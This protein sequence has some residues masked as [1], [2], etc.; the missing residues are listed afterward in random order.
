MA[1]NFKP[2]PDHVEQ[3]SF[4]RALNHFV[5]QTMSVD[6]GEKC[7]NHQTVPIIMKMH[8]FQNINKIIIV[9]IH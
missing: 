3:F 5:G 8:N 4:S 1:T 9:I 7:Q 2:D 6:E